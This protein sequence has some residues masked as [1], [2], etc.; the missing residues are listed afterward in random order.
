MMHGYI[1]TNLAFATTINFWN[2]IV[3]FLLSNKLNKY[4]VLF[5]YFIS[6]SVMIVGIKIKFLKENYNLINTLTGKIFMNYIVPYILTRKIIISKNIK[7]TDV[8][9]KLK[10]IF[11]SCLVIIGYNKYLNIVSQND[12]FYYYENYYYDL[13]LLSF[14]LFWKI[15]I[16]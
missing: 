1:P 5:S 13:I 9:L 15:W 8:N 2:S 4:Y 16:N 3:V 10:L 12:P 6:F 11:I 14:I 7:I